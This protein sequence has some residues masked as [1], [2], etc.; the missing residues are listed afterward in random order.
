M[1]GRLVV[2]ANVKQS[3]KNMKT[4]ALHIKV[5]LHHTFKTKQKENKNFKNSH[6]SKCEGANI[7]DDPKSYDAT[8]H[9]KMR[10][11]VVKVFELEQRI[12]SLD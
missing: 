2:D 5:Q 11:L 4:F 10:H 8:K 1:W 12:K 7:K 3:N 6:A 9:T